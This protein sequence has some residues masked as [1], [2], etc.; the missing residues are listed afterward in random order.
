MF[1]GKEGF[2]AK[3]SCLLDGPVIKSA[4]VGPVNP[5]QKCPVIRSLEVV[6]VNDREIE[7]ERERDNRATNENLEM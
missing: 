4:P 7:R 2:V 1:R 6:T 5:N 3:Q